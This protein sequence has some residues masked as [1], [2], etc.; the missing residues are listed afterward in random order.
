MDYHK[1]PVLF[2]NLLGELVRS[3][4]QF[5]PDD[6]EWIGVET[7]RLSW[8]PHPYTVFVKNSICWRGIS[9]TVEN[10]VHVRDRVEK[11]LESRETH[12]LPQDAWLPEEESL[13]KIVNAQ[14]LYRKMR[15]G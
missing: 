8:S 13:E 5:L 2:C 1:Y 9:A 15:R 6:C 11:D 7:I 12:V 10:T 3:A 14:G 4:L